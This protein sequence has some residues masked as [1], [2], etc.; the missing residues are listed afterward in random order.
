M[1]VAES[2]ATIQFLGQFINIEDG[3]SEQMLLQILQ[4]CR[5][6]L[7]IG[8][9]SAFSDADRTHYQHLR[10]HGDSQFGV[11]NPSFCSF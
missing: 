2:G 5:P 8:K 1:G 7:R 9:K 11:S 6:I 4:G 3:D 10:V